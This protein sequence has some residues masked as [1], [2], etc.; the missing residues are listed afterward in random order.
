[1]AEP[2]HSVTASSLIAGISRRPNS[3]WQPQKP[4]KSGPS[5]ILRLSLSFMPVVLDLTLVL[6]EFI[7]RV[8][9]SWGRQSMH[10]RKS[11]MLAALAVALLTAGSTAL[12]QYG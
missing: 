2:P 9:R 3:N 6:V 8:N 7:K 5:L 12:A 11:T 10:I 4:G 1:M